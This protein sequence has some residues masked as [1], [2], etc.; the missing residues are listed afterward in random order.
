MQVMIDTNVLARFADQDSVQHQIA[1]EALRL[2]Q[3]AGHL[4]VFN[5]QIK[6]EFLDVAERPK[7]SGPGKNGLGLAKEQA[8]EL[9]EQ[10]QDVFG[11]FGSVD[12]S[13]VFATI[14][15]AASCTKTAKSPQRYGS[16]LAALIV[17]TRH[18]TT[19]LM[20]QNCVSFVNPGTCSLMTSAA[21]SSFS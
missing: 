12:R 5:S 11:S 3:G 21:R 1:V 7:G 20:A 6:R 4:P 19:L 15:A 14:S 13:A 10:F 9:I 16:I 8:R 2:L 17:P 18:Q